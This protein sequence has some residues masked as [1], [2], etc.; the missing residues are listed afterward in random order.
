MIDIVLAEDHEIVRQGLRA[1]LSQQADLRVVAETGD[2]QEAIRLVEAHSPALLIADVMMPSLNGLEVA[3]QVTQRFP[4]T[5]VIVLSMYD[6]EPYVLES[7]RNGASAY[8][9]KNS[10]TS[11][12]LKAIEE[13]RA[14]RRYLGPPLS[15]RAI[16]SYL[17]ATQEM[18]EARGGYDLLSHREREIF[19]L[20]I[21]GFTSKDIGERL[22]ISPRTVEKH[23]NNFMN[24]LGLKSQT[25]LVQFAVKHGF[26]PESTGPHAAN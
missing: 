14:G 6:T 20:S 3:W 22:F 25:A 17:H 5:K 2:G 15:Q 1:V 9:L 26:F 24:K 7:F 18:H 12:L 23:R 16:N 19:H 10:G 8:V 4:L 13:V 21:E 11:E